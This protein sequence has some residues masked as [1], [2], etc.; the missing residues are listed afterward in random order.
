VLSNLLFLDVNGINLLQ[1]IL[2]LLFEPTTLL[3]ISPA[4]EMKVARLWR[5]VKRM[6]KGFF[7]VDEVMNNEII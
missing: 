5:A 1:F 3:K 4:G 7:L 2:T 6:Q